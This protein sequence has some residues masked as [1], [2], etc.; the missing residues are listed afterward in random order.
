MIG[1]SKLVT[2][3]HGSATVKLEGREIKELAMQ[4]YVAPVNVVKV[5]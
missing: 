4:M 2:K 3:I 5:K 1:Y